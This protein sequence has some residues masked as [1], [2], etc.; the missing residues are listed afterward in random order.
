MGFQDRDYFR[1]STYDRWSFGSGRAC[2]AIVV[3]NLVV[4]VLQLF[5]SDTSDPFR[6][7]AGWLTDALVMDPD[8][9][10]HEFQ[11]WRLLTAA[12]L[13]DTHTPWHIIMNMLVLWWLGPDVEDLY[14]QKEFVA[15]Y[16]VAAV[17][18]NLFWGATASFAHPQT[19][20]KDVPEFL[21]D[22]YLRPNQALGA[23]GAVFGVAVLCACHYP[24]RTILICWVL[25]VPLWV[26][27][28]IY[29]FADF[30]TFWNRHAFG[31]AVGAHLAG[32]GFGY[33]YYKTNFR[34]LHAWQSFAR[35]FKTKG[36]I[37]RPQ[38]ALR[39]YR[40]PTEDDED[41]RVQ[42]EPVDEQLEAK[43]DAV[44]AKL[45]SLGRDQLSD[46]EKQILE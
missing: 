36:G 2:K 44:L 23:S 26:A 31:V 24:W 3:I 5:T 39:L 42:R 11:I 25:P 16:L 32:A 15:F 41:S 34:I 45:S 21:T 10:F 40:P 46:E 30:V 7:K 13:H 9:V 19:V 17:V 6:P 43:V 27:V 28:G 35:L 33:L 29:V 8:K 12:F 20:P 4:F 14:G 18:S 37:R 22:L 38:T 1:A